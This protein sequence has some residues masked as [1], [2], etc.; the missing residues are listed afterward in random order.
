[1]LFLVIRPWQIYT[2]NHLFTKC[3]RLSSAACSKAF[4]CIR[5]LHCTTICFCNSMAYKHRPAG[6][7]LLDT[8]TK[9]S[10]YDM[11]NFGIVILHTFCL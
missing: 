6:D 7:D 8:I 2:K 1:M 3:D 5:L 9:K 11:F 4:T 10:Y